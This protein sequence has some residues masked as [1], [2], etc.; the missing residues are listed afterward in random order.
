MIQKSDGVNYAEDTTN[1]LGTSGSVKSNMYCDVPMSVLRTSPYSLAQG[2]IVK[3][4]AR[5]ENAN[6]WGTYS[7]VNI[8]GALVEITPQAMTSFGYDA[9]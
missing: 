2:S 7:Q 1:C 5:A 8:A 9:T 3:A 6:G 4:I